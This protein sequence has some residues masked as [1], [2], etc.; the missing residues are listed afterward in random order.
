MKKFVQIII[1]L[2]V[3]SLISMNQ[4]H[5]NIFDQFKE[6]HSSLEEKGFSFEATHMVD[7]FVNT[8]GGL[9]EKD[10]YLTNTD[11]TFTFDTAKLGFWAD[12]TFRAHIIDN[13]GG[14][15]LTGE[16][17]G[18][19]QS[20][21]SI[22][23]PRKTW[24]YELWYEHMFFEDALAVLLGIHDFNS[25]FYVSEYAGLY[26]NGSFGIGPEISAGGRASL[27]P[28]TAPAV[29]VKI[30]PADQWELLVGVY[31]GDPGD[32]EE[33][34]FFPR[35]DFD[36]EGG[37]FIASEAAYHFTG[38]VLPGFIKLGV[39]HNTGEFGDVIEVKGNGD[40]VKQDG[41]TGGYLV[42]DKMLYREEDAQGPGAF[43]QFGS[44]RKNVNKFNMYVGGGFNYRGLIPGRD[45]DEFGIAVAHAVIN[46]D[47]VD[48]GGRND[49]ETTI[50]TTY[51]AQ[52]TENISM[53]PD[54]QY[55]INP[56][57]VTDIEDAFV[58]GLRFEMAL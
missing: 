1:V 25:D 42:V 14:R 57:A 8:T 31:D 32:P 28:L 38:D 43:L 6:K 41:N 40:P 36:Q 54:L 55:V 39:W 18:D 37:A 5:A 11:I 56:G 15:K 12:G 46:N 35:S 10:T 16:I 50:E 33:S 49:H 29:R 45:E 52:I 3:F 2:T 27:F 34:S 20:V 30:K 17:V 22:E 23:G 4:A 44:N 19:L 48:A 24:M 51:K 21:S 7:Y 47:L 9:Q 58:A 26:V 13:S 53:Q